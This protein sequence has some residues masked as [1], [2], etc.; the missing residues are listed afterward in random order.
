MRNLFA[1]LMVLA[2][3]SRI[4]A[5]DLLRF[6]SPYSAVGLGDLV[7]YRASYAEAMG[8][9]G[10]ALF[11]YAAPGT[12][13]PAFLGSIN[14]TTAGTSALF[15]TTAYKSGSS[16]NYGS[17]LQLNN[18]TLLFPLVKNKIGMSLALLPITERAYEVDRIGLQADN[19]PAT[20]YDLNEVGEGNMNRLE[21]GFGFKL[22]KNI[23]AGYAASFVFGS[24]SR[25][26]SLEFYD[27]G[28]SGSLRSYVNAHRGFSHRFGVSGRFFKSKA[29]GHRVIAGAVFELPAK[30]GV[31][32]ILDDY[33]LTSG[34]VTGSYPRLTTTLSNETVTLPATF[35]YGITWLASSQLSLTGEVLTQN[36]SSFSY[37]DDG[38]AQFHNRVRAGGGLQWAPSMRTSRAKWRMVRYR[39]G[40]T[41]D[42]GYLEILNEKIRSTTLNAGF[43]FPSPMSGSSIDV[44]FSYGMRGALSPGLLQENTFSARIALNLSEFMFFKRYIQ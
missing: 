22:T 37:P 38:G 27:T 4:T 29:T 42:T 39:A 35:G 3:Q 6:G 33:Y 17:Q 12:A 10:I 20:Q 1:L 15:R 11:N 41:F 44:N 23:Y 43:T 24:L 5:Q 26:Q 30:V 25:Q 21:A 19:D 16:L 40:V 2:L 34:T 28:V 13:N 18:F 36:W 7:D 8:V 14:L 32:R 31:E 9:T